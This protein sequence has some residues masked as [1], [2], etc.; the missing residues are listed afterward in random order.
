MDH[1]IP[2]LRYLSNHNVFHNKLFQTLFPS[3]RVPLTSALFTL[4]YSLGGT[5][6]ITAG[7]S[8][9]DTSHGIML[10][11]LR[12]KQYKKKLFNYSTKKWMYRQIKEHVMNYSLK[13]AGLLLC[14]CFLRMRT[15]YECWRHKFATNNSQ[16]L[17]CAQLS[18]KYRNE[19]RVVDV[20][21]TP[22]WYR[23]NYE[24]TRSDYIIGLHVSTSLL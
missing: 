9:H 21:L 20:K 1:C 23:K 16:N 3:Q 4:L 6:R 2:L 18:C 12:N 7:R 13:Q 24:P 15:H 8:I 10:L 5:P 14:D 17:S 19:N 22:N 11:H